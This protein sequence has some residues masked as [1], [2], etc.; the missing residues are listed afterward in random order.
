[1][2]QYRYAKAYEKVVEEFINYFMSLEHEFDRLSEV[3]QDD[4]SIEEA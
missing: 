2:E 4:R 1:M 3:E